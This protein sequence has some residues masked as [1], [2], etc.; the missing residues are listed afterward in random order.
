MLVINETLS[1]GEAELQETFVRSAGPG[2]QNVNKVATATQLRFDL[3]ANTSLGPDQK[4]RLRKL[5]GFRL[6]KDDVIIIRADNHRTQSANR[7]EA[8]RRLAQ[9]IREALPRPVKRIATRPTR[10]SIKRR[11]NDKRKQGQ[12]K[13]E[14]RNLPPE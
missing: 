11:L 4:S 8:R 1:I 13:S 2:G 5:A 10:A 14:R 12:K 7:D 9:L 3:G 6:T